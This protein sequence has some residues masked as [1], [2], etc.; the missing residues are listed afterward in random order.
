MT[1]TINGAQSLL[2]TLVNCDVD[3]CFSNPGTSEMHFLAALDQQDGMRAILGLFEGVV[4]GAADGYGR[5]AGKPACT[6]LH[7]GPGLANGLAN[8]HN[9]RR[10]HTPIVNVVG[11]HATYHR[12]LDAPLTSDIEGFAAPVSAWIH[13]SE[14]AA[15]VARDGARAV[16]ASVQGAGQIATLIL[17]ADTAWNEAKQAHTSLA[18][19]PAKAIDDER[20][21]SIAKVLLS[22]E[23]TCIL[24]NNQAAT[25]RGLHLIGKIAAK[26]G[27][28]VM[29][30]TFIGR[31]ERGVG[32]FDIPRLPYFAEQAEQ[33]LQP[34]QHIVLIDTKAP[35]SFFAYPGIASELTPTHALAHAFSEPGDDTIAALEALVDAVGAESTPCPVVELK[36]PD[37]A[38]GA[39]TPESIAQ[40]VAALMPHQAIIVNEAATGGFAIPS[41]TTHCPAHSWLDLTG[42]AI[43]MGIPVATGAAVAC[44][45]RAVIDLQADGSAMYTLQALWTQ[46]R[47]NL[48]VTTVLFSNR[49]YAILQVEF[50]R[51]GATN[52]G[53]KAMDMMDLS[54]PDLNWVS[55]AQGM[56]VDAVRVNSAEAFNTALSQ[57]LA[58]PGPNLIEAVI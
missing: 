4:T 26:T 5:M 44:P 28:V 17:P 33:A 37:P 24:C 11:E 31:I 18:P 20:V 57:A 56:G 22:G 40:T 46:A 38:T 53:R 21:D 49:K 43:G 41:F 9:A 35:V 15:D 32:R 36:C 48:N 39:L 6:L 52:P 23:P 25:E 50:M 42:G 2:Q 13:T 7:L 10:A 27:A 8:L 47:E 1:E 3:V 34:F 19:S 30:D 58:N 12:H 16:Q 14:S 55:L 54:R 45:D 29:G 51:V